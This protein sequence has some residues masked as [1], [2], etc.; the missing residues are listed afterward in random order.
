MAQ[1]IR[2]WLG[3]ICH[4]DQK[5]LHVMIFAAIT[6]I[7]D[8]LNQFLANE[9]G[10]YEDL[11]VVSNILDANGVKYDFAD[12]KIAAF[13]VNI[14]RE[15]SSCQH[16]FKNMSASRLPAQHPP[17]HVNLYIMFAACFGGQNYPEALKFISATISFFQ[18]NPVFDHQNTPDLDSRVEKL[19]L[20]IENLSFND[21][22]N[23]WGVLSGKYMP[24][25]LYKVRMLTFDAGDI[26]GAAPV[27]LDADAS[28]EKR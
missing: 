25:V 12:N 27:V 11:V 9:F 4:T 18:K 10:L 17:L 1:R 22:S 14:E 2:P 24:S 21:L 7:T 5:E 28:A 3:R 19:L 26:K 16:H 23:L 20:S 13:L 15:A 6:S 8:K